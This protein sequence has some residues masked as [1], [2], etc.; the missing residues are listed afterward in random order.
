MLTFIPGTTVVHSAHGPATVIGHET[1]QVKGV[2]I[3]YVKLSVLTN[4]LSVSVPIDRA[5]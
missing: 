1:R 2:A 5:S 4:A 3:E